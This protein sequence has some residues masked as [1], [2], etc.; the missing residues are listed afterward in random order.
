M[1]KPCP[2]IKQ[3]LWAMLVANANPANYV[4]L[5]LR[6]LVLLTQRTTANLRK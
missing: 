1:A 3:M 2:A 4:K 5:V 6:R